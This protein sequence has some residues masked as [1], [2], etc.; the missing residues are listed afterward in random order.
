MVTFVT[1]H[2]LCFILNV[3][4]KLIDNSLS[5]EARNHK[6]IFKSKCKPK[7]A[8]NRRIVIFSAKHVKI[9]FDLAMLHILLVTT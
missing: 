6:I 7:I 5:S 2:Q 8:S 4:G 1:H 9:I 3:H